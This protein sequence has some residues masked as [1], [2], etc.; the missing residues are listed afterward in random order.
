MKYKKYLLILLMTVFLGCNKIY[1]AN[2]N[3]KVCYYKSNDLKLYTTIK[4][5]YDTEGK[6]GNLNYTTIKTHV[7]NFGDKTFSKK[8]TVQNITEGI[9][10]VFP[11]IEISIQNGEI[12]C[13]KYAVTRKLNK[14]NTFLS[15]DIS[16]VKKALDKANEAYY[17]PNV[18]SE[19]FWG[20]SCN[21]KECVIGKN[22][23]VNCNTLFGDSSDEDSLGRLI[24]DALRYVQIIVPI[25]IILLG[26]LD[27]AK[28]VIASKEDEIKKA[29]MTF[30]KRLIAGVAVFFVP[31]LVNL[32]MNLAEIVWQDA[33][34]TYC[35]IKELDKY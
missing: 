18:S 27:L 1:A 12:A 16:T 26:S 17:A 8:G 24:K 33:G 7:M 10:W 13:P 9:T 35:E 2:Q 28:A 29:Q 32:V 19:V 5:S 14:S 15:N 3:E 6:S 4:Y 23:E 25:L 21:G 30:V 20:T 34:Y 11:K 22:A 31:V